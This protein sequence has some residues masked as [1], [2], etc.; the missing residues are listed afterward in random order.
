M[1]KAKSRHHKN[2][3]DDYFYPLHNWDGINII[4]KAELYMEGQWKFMQ[5]SFESYAESQNNV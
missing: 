4:S 2:N 5:T 3:N 1:S